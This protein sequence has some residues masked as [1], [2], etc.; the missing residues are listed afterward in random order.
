M[1]FFTY[2][3][4]T[5]ILEVIVEKSTKSQDGG[6][7]VKTTPLPTIFRTKNISSEEQNTTE[8]ICTD[9]FD[10]SM[11]TI[12]P[13]TVWWHRCNNFLGTV[14]CGAWWSPASQHC[15]GQPAESRKIFGIS[16]GRA[17]RC[18]NGS[19]KNAFNSLITLGERGKTQSIWLKHAFPY[20]Y[21]FHPV[22]AN[23]LQ[24]NL[25][26]P[27]QHQQKV[28]SVACFEDFY[29]IPFYILWDCFC[30]PEGHSRCWRG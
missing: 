28:P 18:L 16:A 9:K 13:G 8:V 19:E 30:R 5:S 7:T 6:T 27:I 11:V 2:S 15:P 12:L 22:A 21:T 20:D 23:L 4:K 29:W 17:E 1:G 26:Q 25:E 3:P 24:H 10:S 14:F